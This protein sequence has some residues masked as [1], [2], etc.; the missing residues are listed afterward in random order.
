MDLLECY[1]K[2]IKIIDSCK[3]LTQLKAARKYMD[4]FQKI[5]KNTFPEQYIQSVVYQMYAEMYLA[6]DNKMTFLEDKYENSF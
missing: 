3:S 1:D 5:F 4:N 2:G 6:Y